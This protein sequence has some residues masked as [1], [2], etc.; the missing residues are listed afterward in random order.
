[1]APFPEELRG[2][3]DDRREGQ[4]TKMTN[5]TALQYENRMG[6]VYY[7]QEGKTRTGKPKYYTGRKLTGTPLSAMPE[8]HEFYERPETAQVVV[9]KIPPSS[10][11]E[12]ER[13]QAEDIVRRASGLKHFIVAIEG[14]ALVV[15]TPSVS[16][17][18]ADRLFD[19]MTGP[20]FGQGS[21]R[22]DA[23][24]EKQIRRSQYM[25]MLRFELVDPDGRRYRAERWCFRGSIDDWWAL[26]G[27]G[28]LAK[29]V[30]PYARHLD[31]ESFFELM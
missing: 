23:F 19:L 30:E 31:R 26:P 4:E 24:R 7:L 6:D 5:S 11:T 3:P 8:G 25:K 27:I 14:D 18:D 16:R 10:I 1:L 29:I 21:A 9:R 2:C 28:P 13:R 12:F 22:A 17:A 15:Y 20:G